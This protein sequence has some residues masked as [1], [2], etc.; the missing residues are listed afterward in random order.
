MLNHSE[1]NII[2]KFAGFK[3]QEVI[4]DDFSILQPM[5]NHI[6]EVICNNSQEKYD[7]F[8]CWFANIV[9]KRH[10]QEWY[11]DDHTRRSGLG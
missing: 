6:K 8:M 2:N 7:Y 4:T 5:L 11:Y 9:Q 3:Y 10:G 1:P